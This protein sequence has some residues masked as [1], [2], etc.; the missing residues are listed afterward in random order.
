MR[1]SRVLCASLGLLLLL[2]ACASRPAA[3]VRD[4]STRKWLEARWIME[5]LS[6]AEGGSR[7]LLVA[8]WTKPV[9]VVAQNGTDVQ[10]RVLGQ[11]IAEISDALNGAHSISLATNG[12]D[13][14]RTAQIHVYFAPQKDWPALGRQWGIPM[15]LP[16]NGLDGVHFV[17]W[18]AKAELESSIIIIGAGL[19]GEMLQHT[20]LEELF[21]AMG[22]RNDS[23]FFPD[24]IVYES[25]DD[26]GGLTRLSERDKKLIRFLYQHVPTDTRPAA[27]A[28][29]IDEHWQ[30]ELQKSR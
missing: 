23:A 15:A 28:G 5:V 20:M 18:N 27:L 7:K 13:L 29:L 17:R 6:S 16:E 11:A 19:T 3:L 10:R 26:T 12:T 8:R 25:G 21:Q 2:S 14:A 9:V 30:F 1:I 24:S 4:F 22:I